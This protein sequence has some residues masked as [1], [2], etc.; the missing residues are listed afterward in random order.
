[1]NTYGEHM[2]RSQ[3]IHNKLAILYGPSRASDTLDRITSTLAQYR[4]RVRSDE[5]NRFLDQRDV[6]LITYGDSLHAS[7]VSG[8]E[9][10]RR[11]LTTRCTEA[12][13][14]VHLLPCFPYSS[15]DGFS[16][17]DYRR[18]HPDCGTW[19]DIAH[20]ADS[21]ELCFDLVIN[22]CSQHSDYFQK[23]LADDPD[24]TDFFITVEASMDT[25]S[26]LRP[27]TLPLFHEYQSA[28]G[29]IWCWTTFSAD[30][31]DWNFSNPAVL[32]EFVDILLA[33]AAAG[34]RMVRLDAIAY[35]W[36]QAGTSCAHLPQTHLV[37]QLLRDILDAAE[38]NLLLL[39]ETNVPHA[40]NISYFGDG[41]NEA[42]V[43]Y[44]FP[45]PPLLLHTL[46][47]ADASVLTRWAGTLKPISPR[48]TFLNFTAS[49]D[50]IG[51]RPAADLLA[52]EDFDRLVAIATDH[53]GAVSYK[54]DQNG[55]PIPYELN[56]NYFDALNNPSDTSLS[57]DTAVN[58]FLL[59]QSVAMTLIGIPAVYI[60]SLLGSRNWSQ[61][62]AQTHQPRSINR[63]KLDL[64]TVL[65]EL[66]DPATLRAMVFNRYTAMLSCRRAQG[67]FSPLALQDILDYGPAFFIVRRESSDGQIIVA[68]HH[69]TAQ[70]RALSLPMS[71]FGDAA[72]ITDLL[73]DHEFPASNGQFTF[74]LPPYSVLWLS[75]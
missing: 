49:H 38:S 59:T 19:S 42:Q 55:T 75:N 21:V 32:C 22:H 27:R 61:G 5:P 1:M 30:Q 58:R 15:D 48:T 65:T 12:I 29:P 8:L 70:G 40:Q 4:D 36:K 2:D 35:L 20:L 41:H 3:D 63:Q 67:T 39:T 9:A 6:L 33:Y 64:H 10:L 52:A 62:V 54:N 43:V 50:G 66:D 53:G 14:M 74:D 17:I 57:I 69:V 56:I 45:L 34:A 7:G 16:V 37:V 51:V 60:H 68:V 44:N 28:H 18:I 11:L 71:L 23:F 46:H 73:T 24:Y 47:R 25:S 26:V 72:T 13:S 31:I